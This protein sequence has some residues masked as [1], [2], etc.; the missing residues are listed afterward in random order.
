MRHNQIVYRYRPKPLEKVI[1]KQIERRTADGYLISV[2]SQESVQVADYDK[3]YACSGDSSTNDN[4]SSTK[5][6]S[7]HPNPCD[8]REI[9][10]IHPTLC[11]RKETRF[12]ERCTDDIREEGISYEECAYQRNYRNLSFD[13]VSLK[14]LFNRINYIRDDN[15]VRRIH[16]DQY[17]CDEAQ[18]WADYLANRDEFC[19]RSGFCMSVWMGED[20]SSDIA[21]GWITDADRSKNPNHCL[22]ATR[23]GLGTTYNNYRKMHIV[24]A[25]FE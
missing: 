16:Q 18:N 25:C 22:E 9:R 8:Q 17:L 15:G 7:Y 3:F 1:W 2:S 5:S 14:H 20:P 6:W 23:I 11:D 24:V 10:A 12:C 4:V 21:F 13:S 19:T